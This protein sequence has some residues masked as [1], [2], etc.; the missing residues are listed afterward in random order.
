MFAS[1]NGPEFFDANHSLRRYVLNRDH[2]GIP[3]KFRL[4]AYI[5]S[6]HSMS[7]RQSGITAAMKLLGQ[8]PNVFSEIAFPPFGFILTIDSPPP[9]ALLADLTY[10]TYFGFRHFRS[11]YIRIPVREVNSY[12]PADFRDVSQWTATLDKNRTN[13]AL[14]QIQT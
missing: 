4:L 13:R 9:D 8:Q 10:F 14:P 6:T 12:F 7:T 5:H 3:S 2:R 1:A 11:E